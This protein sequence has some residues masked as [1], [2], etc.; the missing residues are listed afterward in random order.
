M[1]DGTEVQGILLALDDIFNVVLKEG[2]RKME[3]T[4]ENFSEIFIRG[5]TVRFIEVI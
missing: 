3:N 4:I 5:N 2:F 1:V